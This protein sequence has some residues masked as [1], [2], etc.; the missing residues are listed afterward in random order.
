MSQEP[1]A[2]EVSADLNTLYEACVADLAFFKT[3]Q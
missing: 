3:Q 2:S 1:L